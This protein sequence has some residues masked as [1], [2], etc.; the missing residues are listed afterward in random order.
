MFSFVIAGKKIFC[1]LW[2]GL[3]FFPQRIKSLAL[4]TWQHFFIKNGNY[5]F[6]KMS[7]NTGLQLI[8]YLADTLDRGA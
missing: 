2:I 7:G 5:G 1:G 6:L 3:R 4:R 8:Y